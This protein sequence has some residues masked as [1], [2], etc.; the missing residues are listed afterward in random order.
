MTIAEARE[1]CKNLVAKAPRDV[2]GIAVLV[3]ASFASFGL[4]YLAGRDAGEGST[5]RIEYAPA[6]APTTASADG[7]FV[8]SKNGTKYYPQ[9]CSG[10]DRI[11]P[12]NKVW[13]ASASAAADAGYAPAAHC[14]WR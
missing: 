7:Q 12:A 1:K 14:T 8:A 2:L 5:L 9:D 4:G 6:V 10:A 11:S 3:L 13:F